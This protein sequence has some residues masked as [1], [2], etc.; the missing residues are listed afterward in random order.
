MHTFASTLPDEIVKPAATRVLLLGGHTLPLCHALA[1]KLELVAI[2][3]ATLLEGEIPT[4]KVNVTPGH[5][6]DHLE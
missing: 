1:D 5:V 6:F 4:D 3:A 2:H